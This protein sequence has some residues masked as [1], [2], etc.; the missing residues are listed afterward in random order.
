MVEGLDPD[1][2]YAAVMGPR[3]EAGSPL[4][5]RVGCGSGRDVAVS[6][7]VMGPMVRELTNDEIGLKESHGPL[8]I[9]CEKHGSFLGLLQILETGKQAGSDE[10]FSVSMPLALL[11]LG[12]AES[13]RTMG[14][15]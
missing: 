2:H 15:L 9:D 1:R 12:T 8:Y 7:F 5:I 6:Q 11:P 13:V 4:R 14:H 3:D 10:S